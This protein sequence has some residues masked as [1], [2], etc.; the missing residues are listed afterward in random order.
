MKTNQNS[1]GRRWTAWVLSGLVILF[2]LFDSIF[3]LIAS[4]AVMESAPDLGFQAHHI[5]PLGIMGL[6]STVLHLIPRTA[7]L[8]AVL[9]TGYF[10]GAIATHFR[11]DD[12]L[13]SH[14]LFPVYLAL[15]MWGGLWLRNEGLRR[16]VP[17]QKSDNP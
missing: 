17:L 11:L 2:M 5:I 6:I 8:G 7:V 4:P 14:T 12:P 10:G 13:F 9:L 1:K 15:L 3:K 16:L